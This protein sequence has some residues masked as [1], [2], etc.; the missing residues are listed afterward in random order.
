MANHKR[1]R[2]LKSQRMEFKEEGFKGTVLPADFLGDS[3]SEALSSSRQ[4]KSK[5]SGLARAAAKGEGRGGSVGGINMT[6]PRKVGRKIVNGRG[7][8]GDGGRGISHTHAPALRDKSMNEGRKQAPSRWIEKRTDAQKAADAIAKETQETQERHRK[9]QQPRQHVRRA[10][11]TG[12]PLPP[13]QRANL[14]PLANPPTRRP[15]TSLTRHPT[16]QPPHRPTAPPPHRPTA[17]PHRVK[18]KVTDPRSGGEQS[19]EPPKTTILRSLRGKSEGGKL[20][21]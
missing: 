4:K 2:E 9:R 10:P 5:L 12:P 15:T 7:S 8:S 6:I 21:R 19:W 1:S 17:P 14:S 16:S 11:P 13:C 18:A 3:P 20:S